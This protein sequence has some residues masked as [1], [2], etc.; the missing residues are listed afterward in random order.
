MK[1]HIARTLILAGTL[2]AMVSSIACSSNSKPTAQSSQH[3]D[4][5]LRPAALR[6]VEPIKQP[7]VVAATEKASAVKS[8]GKLMSF[9]SR[10]YGVSFL[11]PW[12][13]SFVSAKAIANS[14]ES[15]R[16]KV[17]GSD[18]Q[19]SLV[20]IEIPKGFYPDT[21]FESGYFVLSLNQQLSQEEC[22][23]KLVAP[24]DGIV[25]T[26]TINGVEYRWL[27]TDNG[28]RGASSKVRDYVNFTND[29]CYEVELGVTTRNEDGLAREVD[30]DQ[31]LRR[32][33]S[34]LTTVKIT[35]SLQTPKLESSA[36]A[37][38]EVP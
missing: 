20:R 28:G 34:I 7:I 9:K 16:P 35:S 24:K 4:G 37:Q 5:V 38:T 3:T 23:A 13:Y 32:L 2:S 12:Q 18:D 1:T 11:Y 22:V 17:D 21:N 25:K 15:L 31:V 30:A 36:K 6:T 10:D 14:E 8:P 27:E 29:T 33:D 26:D 19:M